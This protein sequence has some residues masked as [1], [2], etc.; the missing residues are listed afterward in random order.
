MKYFNE[1]NTQN[2]TRIVS[3]FRSKLTCVRT[4][5]GESHIAGGGVGRQQVYTDK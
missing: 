1:T 5:E 2:N 3:K 4:N